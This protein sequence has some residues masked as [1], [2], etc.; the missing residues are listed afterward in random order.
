[1]FDVSFSMCLVTKIM[2]IKK[3]SQIKKDQGEA[4]I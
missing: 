1:M 2:D 3:K 4:D